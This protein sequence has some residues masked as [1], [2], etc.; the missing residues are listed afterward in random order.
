MSAYSRRNNLPEH[1]RGRINRW[2]EYVWSARRERVETLALSTLPPTLRRSLLAHTRMKALRRVQLFA[3]LDN[4]FMTS[5]V[6]QLQPVAFLAGEF[7]CK[8]GT[9]I[10]I[11]VYLYFKFLFTLG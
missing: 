1:L 5:L 9:L 3:Q 11:S 4:N 8:K 2:L 10:V 6:L 7:V